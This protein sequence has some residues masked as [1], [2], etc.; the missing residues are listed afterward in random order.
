MAA[1]AKSPVRFKN[2]RTALWVGYG[3]IILG[4]VALFDAYEGRGKPRP[5]MVRFLPGP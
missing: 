5:F 1:R 3:G 2:R 4:A